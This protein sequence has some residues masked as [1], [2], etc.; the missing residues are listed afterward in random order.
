MWGWPRPRVP[1][2]YYHEIGTAT[3]KHVVHPRA[4][5]E[6]IDWLLEAGFSPL[7]LDAL[8]EVYAGRRPAPARPVLLSFDDGRGGVLEHA[9]PEL[10]RRSVPAA[11]YLVTDWLD[12]GAVPEGERYSDFV[13]WKDLPALRRAGFTL[14]SHGLRHHNLKRIPPAEAAREIADSKR[15]LEDALGTPVVHWSYPYGRRT[16]ALARMVRRSGY[17][18][19][20]VT[21]E[22]VNGPFAHLLHL[23]RLRVDGREPLSS[24]REKLSGA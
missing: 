3:Q 22:A 19:A 10:A 20:V 7:S 11:L 12:G 18:T 5:A 21:G 2:L 24:L 23:R 9:A 13:S 17:R 8:V 14:G 1:I 4:F 15:R 16:R 6:Q